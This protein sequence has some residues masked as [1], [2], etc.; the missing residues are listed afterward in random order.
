MVGRSKADQSSGVFKVI[1]SPNQT[2]VNGRNEINDSVYEVLVTG[3]C[4]HSQKAPRNTEAC[5]LA[6]CS[7]CHK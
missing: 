3:G 6:E 7:F 4:V 2:F 5:T 1:G